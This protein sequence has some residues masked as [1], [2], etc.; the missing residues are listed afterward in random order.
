MARWSWFVLP[1]LAAC[2]SSAE[3]VVTDSAPDDPPGGYTVPIPG[4]SGTV[5]PPPPWGLDVAPAHTTC[6]APDRPLPTSPASV[7]LEPAFPALTF[8]RP[9]AVVLGPDAA[10]WY[11]LES[12]GIIESFPD[13]PTVTETHVVLDI[14]DRVTS[15]LEG[16]GEMGL[17]GIA[18]HPEFASNGHVYL[19]YTTTLP[20]GSFQSN[21]SRFESPDDGATIDPTSEVV[22]FTLAQPNKNHNGGR[23]GFGPDGMLWAGFGDGG[24]ATHQDDAPDPMFHYG[25]LL[26]FDVDGGTPYAIPPDNPWADGI[27]GLP[28][29]WAVGFRNPWG[30]SIDPVTGEVWVADV[31][32]FTWEEVNLAVPGGNFGWPVYVG[33]DCVKHES[34]CDIP[35]RVDPLYVYDRGSGSAVIGGGVYWGGAIPELRGTYLFADYLQGWLRQLR[36]DPTTGEVV[37]EPLVEG[38][39]ERISTFTTD[40]AGEMLV[41]TFSYV[42]SLQRLVPVAPADTGAPAEGDPFPRLLSE[43]GCTDPTDATL[44]AA[45][46][47]PYGVRWPF[48]VDGLTKSTWLSVPDGTTPTLTDSGDVEL[49]P[50][51]VVVKEI[52]DGDTRVETRLL[53]RH[54]DGDWGG[55]AYGWEGDDAVLTEGAVRVDTTTGTHVVPHRWECTACHTDAAGG[56]LGLELRQ[57]GTTV[58]YPSTGRTADQLLTWQHIGWLPDPLPEVEALPDP[59]ATAGLAPADLDAATLDGWARAWLHVNCSSCHRPEVERSGHLDLRVDT[60]I[61]ETGLLMTVPEGETLGLDDPRL[62]VPGD[63]DRSLLVLRPARTDLHRMP[64]AGV[65]EVDTVAVERLRAWVAGMEPVDV[66]P[67]SGAP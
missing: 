7:T 5:E 31:G 37:V 28:E 39:T 48:W 4:D 16:G 52:R 41:M 40:A 21:I 65:S 27:G 34:L 49:P 36:R 50:G 45:G 14:Q 1:S 26:R 12:E 66:P 15:Q 54:E 9:T 33:E 67:D 10:T 11:V 44:P 59:T 58:D 13:D 63:P 42:G 32:P 30:W 60:P 43:T 17:L 61:D 20:D 56:S 46:L 2:T 23:I 47:V 18:F 25:K 51:S 64:P 57:L 3:K 53:V 55:Y 62:L 8:A 35:D 29:V 38:L 22:L 24:G 6:V 19:S